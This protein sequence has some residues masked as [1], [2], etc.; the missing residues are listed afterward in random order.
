MVN[1]TARLASAEH[2]ADGDGDPSP[3]VQRWAEGAELVVRLASLG[4]QGG[5][6][7]RYEQQ[8]RVLLV[9]LELRRRASSRRRGGRRSRSAHNAPAD[10]PENVPRERLERALDN[11]IADM[12]AARCVQAAA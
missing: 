11:R 5:S 7:R 1:P 3:T 2:L 12:R 8:M 6:R 4:R 9:E 10:E